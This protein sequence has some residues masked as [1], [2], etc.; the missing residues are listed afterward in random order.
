MTRPDPSL[1]DPARYPF[2]CDIETRFGDLDV[3]KHLN[4]VAL[5]G[6][7]EEGRVRFHAA[8]GFHKAISRDHSAMVASLAI[9][10]LGQA[11]Y[12]APITVYAGGGAIGRSSYRLELLLEQEGNVVAFARSV[13]VCM[14]G[15]RPAPLPEAFRASV[16]EWMVRA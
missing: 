9:E 1:L 11:F 12:P 16:Q 5:A 15:G 2:R 3:N 13:M 10:Y 14:N 8:S 6:I 7:V 4:N